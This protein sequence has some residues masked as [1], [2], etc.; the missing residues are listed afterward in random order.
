M[1]RLSSNA[2]LLDKSLY[3]KVRKSKR[4]TLGY[5]LKMELDH[6]RIQVK[7]EEAK[8]CR[9]PSPTEPSSQPISPTPSDVETKTGEEPSRIDECK[10][11]SPSI[12]MPVFVF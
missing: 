6:D 8:D 3:R 1:S 10:E 2:A 5:H 9:T 4:G 7:E 11:E 12:S